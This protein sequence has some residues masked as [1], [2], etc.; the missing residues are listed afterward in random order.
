M[1]ADR[2][3]A[4]TVA[5]VVLVVL[6]AGCGGHERAFR[7]GV[8]TDCVGIYRTLE[9]AELSGAELPLLERG[10]RLRGSRPEDGLTRVTVAGH[11][12][13]LWHA[14]TETGE[15]STMFQE[16]RRLV[17]R[18]GV[19]AVVGGSFGVD[20]VG[21]KQV[22]KLYPGVP[23]IALP[24]GPR[25]VTLRERASNLYRVAPDHGQSV[26]GLATF[27]FRDLGWR[28]AAVLAQNWDLGWGESAA[29]VAEFC[30]LG[31]V[32][33]SQ[34]RVDLVDPSDAERVPSDVDGVAL[35]T[36]AT[37]GSQVGLVRRLAAQL[38]DP[39][40]RMVLGPGVIGDA[41]VLRRMGKTLEGTVGA[42]AY[43]PPNASEAF[44]A[45][46]RSYRAAFPGLSPYLAENE[47]VLGLRNAV[48]SL[49]EAFAR[50]DGDLSQERARLRT[51]L[52]RL[53]TNLLGVP[54]RI[55]GDGQ[56]V[57]SNT[58]VRIGTN[59]S[60]G[61]PGPILVHRVADVDQSIGGLLSRNHVPGDRNEPCRK[62]T[63]PTWAR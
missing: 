46:L 43:P 35:L 63:P 24:D 9:D 10:G 7:I 58:L 50:A 15:F 25:E 49:L 60:G 51:E 48:E 45:Y 41:N 62:A 4:A 32:V 31:G 61:V 40:Q 12:V 17:V 19:D 47:V 8:L 14:C 5:V 39:A 20:A 38:G 27:A 57:V 56:A 29:F 53:R 42:S 54:I 1:T 11:P 16:V 55:D 44:R 36:N 6:A 37:F 3:I 2:W 28:R 18:D 52:G 13:E 34:E 22:A 33:T 21:L 30:A 59:G 23:F 26:A